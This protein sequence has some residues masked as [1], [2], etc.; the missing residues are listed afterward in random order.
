MKFSLKIYWLEIGYYWQETFTAYIPK[1]PIKIFLIKI[2][3]KVNKVIIH[4]II[5]KNLKHFL[6]NLSTP[7]SKLLRSLSL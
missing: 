1:N 7:I 4:N 5:S 2:S 6:K 3:T